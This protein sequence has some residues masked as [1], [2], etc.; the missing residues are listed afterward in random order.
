MHTPVQFQL[1]P[2]Y[3]LHDLLHL[4][5]SAQSY[6]NNR[7]LLAQTEVDERIKSPYSIGSP[8][9]PASSSQAANPNFELIDPSSGQYTRNGLRQQPPSN[10]NAIET[11]SESLLVAPASGT[12]SNHLVESFG[13]DSDNDFN[14]RQPSGNQLF[15]YGT[16][17]SR[18]REPSS[19]NPQRNNAIILLDDSNQQSPASSI[20]SGPMQFLDRLSSIELLFL[21]SSLMFI[22]LMALGLAGSYYCLRRRRR[23]HREQ[24][25]SNMLRAVHRR[26]ASGRP[27]QQ[28]LSPRQYAYTPSS[29]ITH[30]NHLSHHSHHQPH[31]H[32]GSGNTTGQSSNAHY[33]T[34]AATIAA[35]SAP[36]SSA[37]SPDSDLS[38]RGH[39]LNS[40]TG[41]G[42][43]ARNQLLDYE[44]HT[45]ASGKH[46]APVGGRRGKGNNNDLDQQQAGVGR[47]ATLNRQ[48]RHLPAHWSTK[49]ARQ[50][51]TSGQW[52]MLPPPKQPST[53]LYRVSEAAPAG[54]LRRSSTMQ[55]D[56]SQGHDNEA[57]VCRTRSF[58]SPAAAAGQVIS[59]EN[60]NNNNNNI[61]IDDQR[62][63]VGD[64]STELR[65]PTSQRTT[66]NYCNSLARQHEHLLK[67][68]RQQLRRHYLAQ[69]QKDKQQQVTDED[70][71]NDDP[72]RK[73]RLVLKRI[74]DSYVTNI[75]EIVE[76]EY[77]ERDST[78]PLGWAEWR[79]AAHEAAATGNSRN[80][81]RA[82]RQN[83]DRATSS[84]SDDSDGDNNYRSSMLASAAGGG[85]R[86][87]TEVDV[88]FTRS[89][90][91]NA[92]V[93]GGQRIVAAER[94]TNPKAAD[95]K[96][97]DDD[98]LMI[99]PE[100]DC[101]N[102]TR[103][104]QQRPPQVS[105]TTIGVKHIDNTKKQDNSNSKRLELVVSPTSQDSVSYV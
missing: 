4:L 98:D 48:P 7:P 105:R 38:G 77:L 75:T 91:R 81:S 13:N 35:L 26:A 45:L 88:D 102:G 95:D 50:Q 40:S 76:K 30:H 47:A 69:Q 65:P 62:T 21:I 92:P 39:L 28:I 49:R 17:L 58:V 10:N 90:M 18:F 94:G 25:A 70:D 100:Y 71:D 19:P 29:S 61:D 80:R 36:L 34:P 55:H 99:S 63:L 83:E 104:Q 97:Q 78:R 33:T 52:Y 22:V 53:G 20:S 42:H 87:L 2:F 57:F 79:R 93:G 41:G 59:D 15:G 64:N 103:K 8:S 1:K 23:M 54:S 3:T 37:S 72:N 86:S 67:H 68:Q 16:S 46:H 11:M 73:A 101:D 85:M 5:P 31:R 6:N 14:P 9:S 82:K 96:D 74:D 66:T 56:P 24:T 12:K 89:L 44:R 32:L 84:D 51:P 27:T 60:D 43:Y